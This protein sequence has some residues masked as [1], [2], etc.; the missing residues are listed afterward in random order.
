MEPGAGGEAFGK[1]YSI[2]LWRGVGPLSEKDLADKE[3][4]E[5]PQKVVSRPSRRPL[6][7]L[8]QRGR[9]VLGPCNPFL[10]TAPQRRPESGRDLGCRQVSALAAGC[11]RPPPSPHTRC[12]SPGVLPAGRVAIPGGDGEGRCGTR[13][14]CRSG[15]GGLWPPHLDGSTSLALAKGGTWEGKER[16]PGRGYPGPLLIIYYLDKSLGNAKILR[17]RVPP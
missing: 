6:A 17:K 2:H 3:H 4:P 16:L 14:S 11:S 15:S 7:R 13:G 9:F 1:D 12:W 10:G 8:P 5:G